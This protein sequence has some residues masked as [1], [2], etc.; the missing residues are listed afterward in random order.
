MSSKG[1]QAHLITAIQKTY[2]ANIIRVNV[3]NEISEDSRD[4]TQ[5]VRDKDAHYHL[6]YLIY[7]WMKSLGFGFRN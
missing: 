3:G 2:T 5:G 7:I 1:I 6:F 4:I